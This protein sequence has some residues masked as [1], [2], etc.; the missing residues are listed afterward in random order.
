MQRR[1]LHFLGGDKSTQRYHFLLSFPQSV[2]QAWPIF[3]TRPWPNFRVSMLWMPPWAGLTSVSVHCHWVNSAE[4]NEGRKAWLIFNSRQGSSQE[5]AGAESWEWKGGLGLFSLRFWAVPF[6]TVS[7][8]L[9]SP[10]PW[11]SPGPSH[12]WGWHKWNGP[13]W[14]W[15]YGAR[16]RRIITKGPA[17]RK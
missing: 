7:G 16:E 6:S 11:C 10:A 3:C 4:M 8:S 2:S 13:F 5:V 14:W 9:R 1:P 17:S 12:H 15:S